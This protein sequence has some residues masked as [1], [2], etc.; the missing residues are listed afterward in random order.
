MK[1]DWTLI[2][3]LLVGLLIW[4][5]LDTLFIDSLLANVLPSNFEDE[6]LEE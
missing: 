3:P 6:N 4:K 1:I 5:I 2:I